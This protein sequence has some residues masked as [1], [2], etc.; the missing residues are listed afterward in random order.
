MN[1]ISET[2]RKKKIRTLIF[3]P[4]LA[5]Y[6]LDLFNELSKTL[7][8]HVVFF[9]EKVPYYHHHKRERLE[10]DLHCEYLYHQGK[11][12]RINRYVRR[13]IGHIIASVNPDVVVTHEFLSPTLQIMG[14]RL[15]GLR[16]RDYG[17]VVWTTDNPHILSG[18]GLLKLHVRQYMSKYADALMVYSDNVKR[19]YGMMKGVDEEKIFLCANHQDPKIILGK[20]HSH[21]TTEKVSVG[22]AEDKRVI[23]YVGRLSS[24]KNIGFLVDAFAL[25]VE[26]RMNGMLVI[27]GDG[28][29][30]SSLETYVENSGQ[31]H[32]TYFA[33]HLEPEEIYHWYLISDLMVLPSLSEPYGAV[34]NEA[35][36][37]GLPVLCSKH[38]G[39]SVL[40][41]EGVN[42]YTFTPNN[43]HILAGLM[44]RVLKSDLKNSLSGNMEQYKKM[45][46]L[47]KRDVK[48]F[49]EAVAL[50]NESKAHCQFS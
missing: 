39:A 33:G 5:P 6:R 13:G 30:R 17:V 10:S 26:S 48:S 16:K 20:K 31:T 43:A 47:F 49:V 41:D 25:L 23:L 1:F 19:M 45:R 37:S 9:H 36:I 27:I 14:G 8:L 3:H 15:T 22:F 18:K 50:A 40:I 21:R 24:E 32:H 46:A 12:P 44:E 11:V 29:E 7:D 2:D 42:G 34:V 28:P 4:A 35:I 38:A